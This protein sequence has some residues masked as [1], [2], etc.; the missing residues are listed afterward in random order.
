MPFLKKL[1]VGLLAAVVL[2]GGTFRSEAQIT[3]TD[4]NSI[5]QLLPNSQAGMFYWAVQNTP[6]TFQNQLNQQWFWYGIGNG[7]VASIDTISGPVITGLTANTVT[8]TYFDSL[9]RFNLSVNY[10]L[11]GGQA[12]SGTA[13]M[14][15]D[16]TINNTSGAP[17]PFH[18]YQ[19]SDFNMGGDG[20]NDTVVLSQ[21]G[22]TMRFNQ[23]DQFDTANI[24]EVT[25]TPNANHAEADFVPNTLNKLNSGGPVLLDDSK[26][27]AGPGDVAWAFEWDPT[28]STGGS[29][30]ISKDKHMDVVF[31]PEPS[32]FALLPLSMGAWAYIKRRRQR[33]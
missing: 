23:S 16:I 22:F 6:S 14:S 24:V 8:T 1:S 17:L 2:Y 4:N 11:H 27:S 15:E 26:T 10:T 21:N 12:A 29:F 31:T 7:P 33:S 30:L 13:D 19:Y 20:A 28:I 18:F 3:L 32:V 5:A 25:T 9:G